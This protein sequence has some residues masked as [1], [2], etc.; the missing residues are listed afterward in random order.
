MR[1]KKKE[2]RQRRMNQTDLSIEE[3]LDSPTFKKFSSALERIFDSAEDINFGSLDPSKYCH[4]INSLIFIVTL[5][6][7]TT[8]SEC[9]EFLRDMVT[10][11]HEFLSFSADS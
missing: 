11:C 8:A 6:T 9:S 5:L 10:Y 2:K 3:L 7:L 4:R 1:R